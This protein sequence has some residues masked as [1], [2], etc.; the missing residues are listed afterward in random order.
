[1]KNKKCVKNFFTFFLNTSKV[2]WIF[3][4]P[5][6]ASETKKQ[7]QIYQTKTSFYSKNDLK[8]NKKH[9]FSTEKMRNAGNSIYEYAH[10]FYGEDF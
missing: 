5:L 4:I 8:V 3:K 9:I 10:M 1:M 2:Q 7:I 6:I